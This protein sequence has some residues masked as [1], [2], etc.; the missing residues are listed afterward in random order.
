MVLRRGG[1]DPG[2]RHRYPSGHGRER[3]TQ[4]D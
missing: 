4:L 1:H 2:G 3:E